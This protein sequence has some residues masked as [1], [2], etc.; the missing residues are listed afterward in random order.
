MAATVFFS[1]NLRADD[2]WDRAI[3]TV[4]EENDSQFSDR[5]YTQGAKIGFLSHDYETQNWLT[6]HVP[7]VGYDVAR[8][9]WGLELGQE[10]YTPEDLS[11][12]KLIRDDRPYAGWL[13]G[14]LIFQQRGSN[15]FGGVMATFRIRAGVV[16]PES[17]ADDTQITWH[18]IWGFQHPSGWR[19]QLGTEVGGE[20]S[21][22][23]RH[24]FAW[25][26]DW[27][28]QFLPEAGCNLG[29]VRT[30][31]HAGGTLRL[32]YDIPN[33]FGVNDSRPGANWGMYAFGG[34]YGEAVLLDIF[35]DGNN[36]R[37]SPNVDKEPFIFEGRFG[38]AVTSRHF[39]ISVAHIQRSIE[40]AAQKQR[41]GF[42][43]LTLT[44]K[45]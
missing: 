35:L 2:G 31:F 25:G 37:R 5:H 23:R 20:F 8:W 29:N 3:V 32:G 9:K 16:G 12:T 43:S 18:S 11:A 6:R 38:V 36:F 44:M 45:F 1:P 17:Q 42:T 13:Y 28:I 19:H 14:G 21:Y 7:S 24:R 27:S 4:T 30:D 22:D 40:F 15:E 33:E 26:D 41:D 10:I 34:L 39:E